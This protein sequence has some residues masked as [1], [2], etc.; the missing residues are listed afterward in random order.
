M[1]KHMT[2][3]AD[4]S[5]P[6]VS[7]LYQDLAC[8]PEPPRGGR[9]KEVSCNNCCPFSRSPKALHAKSLN[10]AREQELK[11]TLAVVREATEVSAKPRWMAQ[12]GTAGGRADGHHTEGLLGFRGLRPLELWMSHVDVSLGSKGSS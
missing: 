10:P 7:G 3:R 4:V 9:Q 11:Q 6:E 2:G 12:K 5:A 8:K 1:H